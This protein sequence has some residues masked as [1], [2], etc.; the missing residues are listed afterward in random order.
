MTKTAITKLQTSIRASAKRDTVTKE[1]QVLQQSQKVG[2]VHQLFNQYQLD[3]IDDTS[4]VCVFEKSRRI[5]ASFAES[6]RAN[7]DASL[8]IADT[9]YSTFNLFAA[10]KFIDNCGKWAR[11]FNQ[12]MKDVY[13][14]EIIDENKILGYSLTYPN[15]R[16]IEA[17]PGDARSNRDK[18]G[19]IVLDEFAFRDKQQEI[20]K[21]VMAIVMRGGQV[22]IL[23]THYGQNTEF[24]KLCRDIESGL[25]PGSLHQCNFRKAIDQGMYRSMVAIR[26]EI[27]TPEKERQWESDIR[28]IYRTNEAEELDCIASTRNAKNIFIREDFEYIELTD[29]ERENNLSVMFFDVAATAEEKATAKNPNACYSTYVTVTIVDMYLVVTD[30]GAGRY[31]ASEG[32]VWMETQIKMSSQQTIPVVELE[33][34][35]ESIK[36]M[37]YFKELIAKNT[38]KDLKEYP[39]S[40]SK[41]MRALP[42]VP[43]IR[44]RHTDEFKVVVDSRLKERSIVDPLQAHMVSTTLVDILTAFDGSKKTLVNDLVD[45][46]TG[47]IGYIQEFIISRY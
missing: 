3:W 38:G 2:Y 47:A 12:V 19:V 45:A 43:L 33:P 1:Q 9:T 29:Y 20:L 44:E 17:V 32:D 25:I 28:K 16:R 8:D 39:P 34:G 15:G 24:F 23:S 14:V 21:A 7:R 42:T 30:A 26:G 18:E 40:K 11:A 46:F 35:S 41:I 27:W 4:S 37:T 22:R 31:S 10:K 13:K 5:G 6:F 36:W